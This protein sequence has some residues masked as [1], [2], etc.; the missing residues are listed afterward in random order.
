MFSHTH[1]TPPWRAIGSRDQKKAEKR[2][3][4]KRKKLGT[5]CLR[6]YLFL[7]SFM[8]KHDVLMYSSFYFEYDSTSPLRMIPPPSRIKID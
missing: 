8:F 5:V 1:V 4:K 7:P 3:K 2:E 6:R